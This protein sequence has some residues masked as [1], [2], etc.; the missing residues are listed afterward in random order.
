[1]PSW[2]TP[3]AFPSAEQIWVRALSP[4]SGGGAPCQGV[5]VGLVLW[6]PEPP[7]RWGRGLEKPGRRRTHCLTEGTQHPRPT[8]RV[9]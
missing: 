2:V 1:M 9:W 7:P 3:V 4:D 5:Q 6:P 8:Y